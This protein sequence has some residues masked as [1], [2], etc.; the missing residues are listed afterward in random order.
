MS[1][2]R[3]YLNVNYHEKNHAKALGAQWDRHKRKWYA[4]MQE[5]ELIERWGTQFAKEL[6]KK[7]ANYFRPD[8][9]FSFKASLRIV[10][11]ERQHSPTRIQV[12]P[13]KPKLNNNNA[14]LVPNSKNEFAKAALCLFVYKKRY[15]FKI[16]KNNRHKPLGGAII[17]QDLNTLDTLYRSLKKEANVMQQ[18][19]TILS[20]TN[21]IH[22]AV[23]YLIKSS[24][25]P[26]GNLASFTP[27]EISSL[28]TFTWTAI[29]AIEEFSDHLTFK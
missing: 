20:N 10:K 1:H 16:T 9:P 15:Y 29:K 7:T 19:L 25:E 4:P 3:T 12:W 23:Y 26:T 11:K 18:D 28:K 17:L 14:A 22:G 6:S 5:P 21:V 24:K 13:S 27:N 8:F 2:R